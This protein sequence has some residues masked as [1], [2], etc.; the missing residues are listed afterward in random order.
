MKKN[1]KSTSLHSTRKVE[2]VTM[3]VKRDSLT[4]AP[5]NPE[6]RTQL[7]TLRDLRGSM[8][9]DGFWEWAPILVDQGGTIIDGHRRWTCA[10][11]LGIDDVPVTVVDDDAD[12]VWAT[13]NGT[14]MNLSG[15]QAMQAV[16]SGLH[17]R[18]PK[19]ADK[20]A[21][22]ESIVGPDGIRELGQRGI[23]PFVVDKALFIARNTGL[24]D[25]QAFV[26][27]TIFWL[28]DHRLMST[29]AVRAIKSGVNPRLIELA[30]REN[31]PLQTNYL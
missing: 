9:R 27:K 6:I 4:Q 25:D 16:A 15:A 26:K 13:F 20:L 5:W 14:H 24:S 30:I 19:Y 29:V 22:L 21:K 2:T 23:S 10:K 1:G 18:P 17:T 3:W 28:C 12:R 8:E 11:L 7:D 31:R